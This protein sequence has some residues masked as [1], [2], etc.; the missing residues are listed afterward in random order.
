MPR[1]PSRWGFYGTE[2]GPNISNDDDEAWPCNLAPC[3]HV[4]FEDVVFLSWCIDNYSRR[5]AG[6]RSCQS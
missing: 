6:V 5:H 4:V 2:N 3:I 1:R